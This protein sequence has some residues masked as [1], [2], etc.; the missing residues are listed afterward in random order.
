MQKGKITDIDSAI[1]CTMKEPLMETK[2]AKL[3]EILFSSVEI[4][5]PTID[6]SKFDESD[7]EKMKMEITSLRNQVIYYKLSLA[8]IAKY[9]EENLKEDMKHE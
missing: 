9:V 8:I 3:S 2:R 6:K 1:I 7:I 4:S 5:H